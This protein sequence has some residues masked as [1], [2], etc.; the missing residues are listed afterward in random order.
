M[1]TLIYKLVALTIA[2]GA[3][4]AVTSAQTAGEKATT[5]AK[6]NAVYKESSIEPDVV[7]KGETGVR[8]KVSFTAYQMKGVPGQVGVRVYN[9][10]E[11]LMDNDKLDANAEGE[12]YV[13][14]SIKPGFDAAEFNNFAVFVPYSAFDLDDGSYSLR[15]DIDLNHADGT[16]IAHLA[17]EDLEYTQ[18]GQSA[19]IEDPGTKV[20]SVTIDY[21]VT[22]NNKRGM[23]V[24]VNFEVAGMKGVDAL[25][26]IRI[27]KSDESYLESANAGFSNSEGE[28]EVTYAIKPGYDEAVY[29]DATL[30]IPYNEMIISR[31]TWDLDLDIDLRYENGD[32]IRH[33]AFHEFQFKRP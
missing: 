19:E 16:L 7:E 1:K 27:R 26:A 29:E 10:E 9:D 24:H 25:L 28:F 3:Y 23:L 18:G 30:F 12:V 14:R 21:N 20:N 13:S 6:P 17:W 2:L 8:V 33:L 5:K 22:R 15:L 31:G 11:A 32:L 4:A